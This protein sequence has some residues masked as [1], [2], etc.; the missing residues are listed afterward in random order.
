M[1]IQNIEFSIED[2]IKMKTD[3]EPD[4]RL[5]IIKDIS[6]QMVECL[7]QIHTVKYVHQ[8]VKPENFR[9]NKEGFVYVLNFGLT[10]NYMNSNEE[11]KA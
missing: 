1:K 7:K 8:D 5:G 11:H 9:C 6:L 2:Y 10:M 4:K 3:Q